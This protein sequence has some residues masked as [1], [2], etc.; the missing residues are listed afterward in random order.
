[1]SAKL[2]HI[3]C[4][5]A[6]QPSTC[7]ECWVDNKERKMSVIPEFPVETKPLDLRV[8]KTRMYIEKA[9]LDLLTEHSFDEITVNAIADRAMVNRGTFYDH[10]SDKYALFRHIVEQQFGELVQSNMADDDK[11]GIALLDSLT[12]SVCQFVA[13]LNDHCSP[14]HTQG[15]PAI[16][17]FVV[18]IL[19]RAIL[20]AVTRMASAPN[21]LPAPLVAEMVSW[22]IYGAAHHWSK[23]V[24]REPVRVYAGRVTPAI[25]GLVNTS[26]VVRY[27][28]PNP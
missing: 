6:N 3:V 8:R 15:L 21:G 20:P 22:S 13:G 11:S 1:M 26:A 19:A 18:E 14:S 16:D 17:E 24:N 12:V 23:Q 4:D 7:A 10:F 25:L 5:G 2:E 27:G 9:F 28:S